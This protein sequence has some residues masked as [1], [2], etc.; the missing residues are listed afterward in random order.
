MGHWGVEDQTDPVTT[1]TDTPD[2]STPERQRPLWVEVLARVLIG[3]GV[4][5]LLTR[6][7]AQPY[8]IPS[9]SME[10]TLQPGDRGVARVLGVDAEKLE[11]GT[12]IAFSHGST[13]E[14]ERLAEP[15]PVKNLVRHAGDLVGVG[16]S[17]HAYTVK[18]VVGLPGETVS[19]CDD[20]GRVLVDGDPLDEPYVTMDLPF[21][22]E[23]GCAPS[24]T[25]S[26]S[27]RCFSEVTVPGDSYLVLGDNRA[28]SSD[29]V[30]L[31]RGLTDRA[32]DARFVRVDQVVGVV[33][34]R[35][36]PLPP[37]SALRGS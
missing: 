37:G 36:W 8:V 18:R 29:S 4:L 33:G 10:P 27:T 21:S 12:V 9:S 19:C 17:H 25:G 15:N 30:V 13:W 11:R 1:E 22:R 2:T 28:N 34:W 24:A 23:T 5:A 16:P 6:F 35:Y 26:T 14:H 7:V 31:C 32:C 20:S 3:F